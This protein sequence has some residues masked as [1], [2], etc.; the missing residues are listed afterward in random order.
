M[1]FR[2][3]VI[4]PAWAFRFL[5]SIPSVTVTLSG[6]SNMQ[7]LTD[8]IQTYAE[9]KPLTAAEM[10]LLLG[11]ADDMIAKTTV[12]CTG[13]HYCVTKCPQTIHIPEELAKFAKKMGR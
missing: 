4:L 11:I 12:P 8:N 9:S 13:C 3:T 7:Q 2:L 5:Q 1:V 10:E 6:M